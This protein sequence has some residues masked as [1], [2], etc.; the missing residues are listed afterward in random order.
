MLVN[1]K[2]LFASVI[3]QPFSQFWAKGASV[4]GDLQEIQPEFIMLGDFIAIRAKMKY[5]R[6]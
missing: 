6:L 1:Y 2:T 4:A 5:N 3:S